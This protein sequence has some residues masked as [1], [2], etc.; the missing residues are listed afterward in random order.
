M[1]TNT[2][3]VKVCPRCGELLFQDME[4]C[5][6]CLLDFGGTSSLVCDVEKKRNRRM[7]NLP[8][9]E[10]ETNSVLDEVGEEW[11]KGLPP[12]LFEQDE[13]YVPTEC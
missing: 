4:I 10:P 8:T 9:I 12:A 11:D 3:S 2:L 13:S 7:V 5:Y 1:D 6:G